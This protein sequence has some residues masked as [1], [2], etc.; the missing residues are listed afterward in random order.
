MKTSGSTFRPDIE[1]LRAI[2]IGAVLVFHAGLPWFSGGY[3]GVDVFFVVSGFLIT[4]LLLKELEASGR[5]DLPRFWGRRARRLLPASGLVLVFSAA[6]AWFWLPITE[7][8]VFGGDIVAS[9]WYVINWRLAAREV[10]YLAEGIG[11]S[12]VQHYWSL[13]IEEQFYLIWPVLLVLLALFG[14]WKRWAVWLLLVVMLSS[15][16]YAVYLA[17]EPESFFLSTTRF[18]ELGAGALV[19]FTASSWS[20]VGARSRGIAAWVG[21]GAIVYAV[22]MFDEQT[23]WPSLPTLLPVLGTAALVVGGLGGSVYSPARLL[24]LKPMVLVGGLSY[25]LYL[26]HWP[27]LILGQALVDHWRIRHGVLFTVIAVLPAWLSYKFIEN[28][29]RHRPYFTPTRR[30]LITGAV[31]AGVATLVGVAIMSPYLLRQINPNTT[32]TG[33]GAEALIAQNAATID[34]SKVEPNSITPDPLLAT[35]DIPISWQAGKDCNL[36]QKISEPI[37]CEFGQLDAGKTIAVV[38][39][40]KMRQWTTGVIDVAEK[41]GWRVITS[42]KSACPFTAAHVARGDREY[43]SCN[44]WN[45]KVLND[46]LIFKPDYVVT[47]SR[48]SYASYPPEG[49]GFEKVTEEYIAGLVSNWSK[50]QDNG[51]Q[52][53]VLTDNPPPPEEIYECVAKARSANDCSFEY[54]PALELSG[55]RSLLEAAERT[56]NVLIVDVLDLICPGL[57]MCPAVIGDVLLYRD[58]SHITNTYILTTVRILSD[59]FFRATKGDIGSPLN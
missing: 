34:F 5:I 42:T 43:E 15:F 17:G 19:A 25:S 41:S 29:I 28:P 30:A 27:M 20:Q 51:T 33:I 23:T 45:E 44:Q 7:R 38:G 21:L 47:T 50:L 53:I 49:S 56:G 14:V 13:A 24:S 54:A 22:L 39:D 58:K 26:W 52:V 46:L 59:K 11:L 10:D 57:Q 40:S 2:A 36:D 16:L 6:V 32:E 8:A 37:W 48:R 35:K 1:G 55:N 3:V 18:W 12:P 4:S 9:A 31:A